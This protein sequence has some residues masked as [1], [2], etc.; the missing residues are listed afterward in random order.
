[1]IKMLALLAALLLATS[2][3]SRY[4]QAHYEMCLSEGRP[5]SQCYA[6]AESMRQAHINRTMNN[7]I[8]LQGTPAM[9]SLQAPLFRRQGY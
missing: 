8:Y 4:W 5:Q 7:A 2:C 3:A 1:M 9:R 6:E